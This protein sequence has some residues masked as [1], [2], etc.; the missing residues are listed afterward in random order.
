MNK[1]ILFL[2]L[3]LAVLSIGMVSAETCTTDADCGSDAACVTAG[4]EYLGECIVCDDSDLKDLTTK[5]RSVGVEDD[6]EYHLH[7]DAC[8]GGTDNEVFEFSCLETDGNT[9]IISE[10]LNCNFGEIC[11]DG[12]CIEDESTTGADI[13]TEECTSDVDCSEGY[14][15]ES[16]MTIGSKICTEEETSPSITDD[17]E[18]TEEA[19]TDSES[20]CKDSD[21]ESADS[22]LVPGEVK[23]D[24]II[25]GDGKDYCVSNL[26]EYYCDGDSHKTESIDCA[27]EYDRFYACLEIDDNGFCGRKCSPTRDDCPD[28]FACTGTALEIGDSVNFCEK[29][30]EVTDDNPNGAPECQEP[31]D[32]N[33]IYDARYKYVCDEEGQCLQKGL[34][35]KRPPRP[36]GSGVGM[37]AAEDEGFFSKIW[38]WLFWGRSDSNL[39]VAEETT[40]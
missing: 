20:E 17:T 15:C 16:G 7:Y 36:T 34:L 29:K 25:R 11:E 33:K 9:L 8:V 13:T 40:E 22:Y 21:A 31:Q 19:T 38:E 30:D 32:C 3:G 39:E 4:D 27:D 18:E 10:I 37:G 26:M 2:I 35:G 23:A 14:T 12:A 6:G 5:T 24:S 1:K 28:N